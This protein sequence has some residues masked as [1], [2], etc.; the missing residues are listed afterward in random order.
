MPS[1]SKDENG[2]AMWIKLVQ[3]RD[4]QCDTFV[5]NS[6]HE[7]CSKAAVCLELYR[8]DRFKAESN[9]CAALFRI[10]STVR[11]CHCLCP[12]GSAAYYELQVVHMGGHPQWGFCSEAFEQTNGY[13][14][15]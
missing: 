8:G 7:A 2:A 5:Q 6:H 4:D 15:G 13:S 12:S 9:L 14:N 1:G 3:A 11:A 10:F